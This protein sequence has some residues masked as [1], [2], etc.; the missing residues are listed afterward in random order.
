MGAGW[1]AAPPGGW[2]CLW[3]C[4]KHSAETWSFKIWWDFWENMI[5]IL[6]PQ[7]LTIPTE[8]GWLEDKPF[9]VGGKTWVW[10][11]HSDRWSKT[12]EYNRRCTIFCY[13]FFAQSLCKDLP[14]IWEFQAENARQIEW[15]TDEIWCQMIDHAHVGKQLSLILILWTCRGTMATPFNRGEWDVGWAWYCHCHT[16]RR[17]RGEC[18]TARKKS[19][20]K[21]SFLAICGRF[22]GQRSMCSQD[23]QMILEHHFLQRLVDV[24]IPGARP[25]D[26]M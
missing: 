23:D 22:R 10:S 9:L 4:P 6:H 1:W 3:A 20:N 17:L 11:D 2:W 12:L 19:F 7:R 21:T 25:F 14:R 26:M 15:L 8:N 16:A 24:N 18:I 5:W 13:V